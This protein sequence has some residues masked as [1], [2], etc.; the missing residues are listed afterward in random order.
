MVTT[1]WVAKTLLLAKV[2]ATAKVVWCAAPC[3]R[4]NCLVATVSAPA[5]SEKVRVFAPIVPAL[6]RPEKVATPLTAPTRV[7]P[8]MSPLSMVTSIEI[9][10]FA[11][12][13]PE[14]S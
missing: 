5:E 13:L 14:T 9:A 4:V 10:E 6:P 11:T 7:V 2:D 1:G 12:V 8:V 3:V